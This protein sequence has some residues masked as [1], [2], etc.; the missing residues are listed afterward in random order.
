MGGPLFFTHYSFLG[1][2]PRPWSDPFCNYFENNRAIAQIHYAYALANAGKHKGYGEDVWGLTASLG[3]DG[4]ALS[5]RVT[6]KAPLRP[7]RPLRPCPT[8]RAHPWRR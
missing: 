8:R 7:R 4:Y 5:S 3:P 6:M 1:F 2:D